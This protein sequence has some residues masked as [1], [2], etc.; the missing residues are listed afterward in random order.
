[1]N[2]TPPA[3]S[4]SAFTSACFTDDSSV[5]IAVGFG[6]SGNIV[7]LTTDRGA[8]WTDITTRLPAAETNHAAC[9]GTQD[10]VVSAGNNDTAVLFRSSD[11]GM[12]WTDL[13]SH[14]PAGV[15]E[16]RDVTFVDPTSG[17]A[18]AYQN[19][20][21]AVVVH[22]TDNGDSW[23]TQVL[24]VPGGAT[25]VTLEAIDFATA[26]DGIVVGSATQQDSTVAPVAYVTTNG[27]T[28]WAIAPLP[29]EVNAL[30]SVTAR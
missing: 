25:L 10:L 14:L 17:W 28:S 27:G 24:P 20:T 3:L 5:G 11:G 18:P 21:T 8:T 2:G 29:P 26:N 13:S 16:L 12:T 30:A 4:N 22:T 9:S 23:T 15:R 1:L 6:V 7:F 19:S